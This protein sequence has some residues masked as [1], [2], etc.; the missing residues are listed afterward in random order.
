MFSDPARDRAMAESAPGTGVQPIRRPRAA[1]PWMALLSALLRL[2]GSGAELIRHSERPWASVTFSGSRHNIVLAF[3]VTEA[4]AAGEAFIAALPDHEF[5]IPRQ[6]VADAAII[7]VEHTLLP[8]ARL[9]VEVEL[10]LL[11]D[12]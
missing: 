12:D 11:E 5:T 1:R 4:V 6:L 8:E 10:L 9:I 3:A 2:A 7:A